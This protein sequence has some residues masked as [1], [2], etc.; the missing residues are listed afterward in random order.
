MKGIRVLV[1]VVAMLALPLVA[2]HAQSRGKGKGPR[3]NS[4][5]CAAQAGN[6]GHVPF[7][8]AKRCPAPPDSTPQPP[9]DS[10]P[11]DSTPPDTTPAPSQPPTGQNSAVGMVF[12][13]LNGDGV[14][15][16]FDG[17]MG[18]AGW[19]VQLEWNGQVIA[20]TTTDDNGNYS[21]GSLGNAGYEVCLVSQGSYSQTTPVSGS[22]C[23]G[24][25][26][27]FSF[28][29]SFPAQTAPMNFGEMLQ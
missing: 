28:N 7:G 12:E 4:D 14:R 23:G 11:A 20:T 26:F 1:A 18:L 5:V 10:T 19:A 6:S 16:M 13:D 22:G 21:F 9:P 29:S 8:Q 27:A 25:G 3:S 17:E 2:A 15:Q 24:S